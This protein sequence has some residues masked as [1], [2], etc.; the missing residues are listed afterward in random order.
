LATTHFLRKTLY[1]EFVETV[2]VP[3]DSDGLIMATRTIRIF[4]ADP[5]IT[6]FGWSLLDYELSSGHTTVVKSG[7]ITG[8]SMLKQEAELKDLYESRYVVLWGIEKLLR[9]MIAE[10]KPDYVVSESA[11]QHRFPQAY[12]A[13]VLVIQALRTATMH[14]LKRN[15]HLIAPKESKKVVGQSGSAAK[16]T[17]QDAIFNNPH[18]TLR[19]ARSNGQPPE[20]SEH[21]Y[22]SIAAGL[23]FIETYLPGILASEKLAR[24]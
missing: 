17:V 22:D 24:L 4:C 9:D 21:A 8:K 15:I 14:T 20:I 16:M 7:T 2:V 11:F 23:A 3:P 5:S 19:P 6:N 18:I 10:F 12:A 1:H 13:L